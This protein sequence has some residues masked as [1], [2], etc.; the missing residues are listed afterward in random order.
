MDRVDFI[1]RM[2]EYVQGYRFV[3]LVKAFLTL[4]VVVRLFVSNTSVATGFTDHFP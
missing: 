3:E 1:L 2:R 4:N